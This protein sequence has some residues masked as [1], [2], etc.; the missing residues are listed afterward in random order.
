MFLF[1]NYNLYFLALIL[2]TTVNSFKDNKYNCIYTFPNQ[3]GE[4]KVFKI[5]LDCAIPIT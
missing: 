1:V 5:P 2:T 3:K 4:K